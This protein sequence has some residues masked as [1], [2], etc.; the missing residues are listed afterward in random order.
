MINASLTL[1]TVTVTTYAEVVAPSEKTIK[2]NESKD[3][4]GYEVTIE[5][6]EFAN[7]ETRVYLTIN[8]NGSSN[9]SV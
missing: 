6:I 2:I 7:A 5:K 3:Q 9:F 4:H 1:S 8:N